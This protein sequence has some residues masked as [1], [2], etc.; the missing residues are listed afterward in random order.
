AKTY[1]MP[2]LESAVVGS[3][4]HD[5]GNILD[6]VG[7][8]KRQKS[9]YQ[10]G[11]PDIDYLI[12]KS[13]EFFINTIKQSELVYADFKTKKSKYFK[14]KNGVFVGKPD[15]IFK[16]NEGKFFVVEEKYQYQAYSTGETPNFYDNHINQ[17]LSYIYG[18]S[19]PS[20]DYGFLV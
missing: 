3:Q 7:G 15:Y 14:G 17:L 13:N 2:K 9:E 5:R 10:G 11:A 19:R 20:I 4:L 18:I 6:L 8:D 16:D 1:A 12:S